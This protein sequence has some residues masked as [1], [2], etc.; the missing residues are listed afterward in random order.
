MD[1]AKENI[2]LKKKLEKEGIQI[3]VEFTSPN[4]PQQNGQLERSFAAL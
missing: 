1:N 4:T 2:R 3:Q